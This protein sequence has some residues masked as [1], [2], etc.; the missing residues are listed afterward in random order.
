MRPVARHAVIALAIVVVAGVA[1][2]IAHI[3]TADK[4]ER[5]FTIETYEMFSRGPS[6]VVDLAD[7]QP[8]PSDAKIRE[9]LND[10]SKRMLITFPASTNVIGFKYVATMDDML[11]LRITIRRDDLSLL[12]QQPTLKDIAWRSDSHMLYDDA[13]STWWRPSSVSHFSAAQVSLPQARYLNIL[14]SL[15][16]AGD[17]V[18]VYLSWCET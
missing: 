7:G 5:R 4:P 6:S 15:E 10:C 9:I 8:R 1:I 2:G 17:V 12:L 18:D 13:D 14:Y 3:V 16:T 11:D